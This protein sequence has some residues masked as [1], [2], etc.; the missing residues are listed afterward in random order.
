MM[1]LVTDRRRLSNGSDAIERLIDLVGTAARAGVDL[2]QVR[3]RDL[4]ARALFKL[5]GQCLAATA[6]TPAK[7]VVNDR[8]DVAMA[9]GAHGVHLRGDSFSA[10]T[11]R[12][13]VGGGVVIGRSVHSAKDAVDAAS[14]GGVDYLL[15]GTMFPTSSKGA[16]HPVATVAELSAACRVRVPVLAIGGM[17]VDRAAT[18]ARAGAAGVAGIGLFVPPAGVSAEHHLQSIVASVRSA[19]DTSET[20]P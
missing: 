19:F 9:A 2:I 16:G 13:L 3:E 8:A 11:L 7:V 20:V 17:T 15:F 4:D 10:T 14:E 1:C 6:G 18:V 12:T 5:V